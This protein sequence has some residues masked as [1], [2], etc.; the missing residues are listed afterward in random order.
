MAPVPRI[1]PRD[2]IEAIREVVRENL[3]PVFLLVE[4]CTDAIDEEIAEW[5]TRGR[6]DAPMSSDH[7]TDVLGRVQWLI[8]RSS[9]S[10][11]LSW[12]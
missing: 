3:T 9:A 12:I 7:V 11:L 5:E 2:Q 4:T 1:D 10:D 6:F 8:V